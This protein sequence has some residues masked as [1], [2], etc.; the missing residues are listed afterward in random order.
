MDGA[1]DCIDVRGGD[2]L[3][4]SILSK[5]LMLE[6]SSLRINDDVSMVDGLFTCC[7][8]MDG[9]SGCMA[10]VLPM[11]GLKLDADCG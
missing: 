1:F 4:K 10:L 7:V 8:C 6:M 11:L 9:C 5:L 3:N 2:E